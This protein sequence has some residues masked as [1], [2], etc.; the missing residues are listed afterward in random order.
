MGLE[1]KIKEDIVMIEDIHKEVDKTNRV[2]NK[3][4]EMIEDLHRVAEQMG[5]VMTVVRHHV[6]N[7]KDKTIGNKTMTEVEIEEAEIEDM[8]IDLGVDMVIEEEEDKLLETL[9]NLEIGSHVYY[10]VV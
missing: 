1:G 7:S 8:I 10:S 5:L 6:I 3:E 4:V 2:G 9:Y